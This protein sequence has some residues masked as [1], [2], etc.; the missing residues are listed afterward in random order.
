MVD[1]GQRR[2]AQA[3]AFDVHAI[4]CVPWSESA[5]RWCEIPKD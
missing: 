3:F 5:T 4:V 1:V 2:E